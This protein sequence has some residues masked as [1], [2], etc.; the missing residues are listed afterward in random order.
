M[1]KWIVASLVAIALPLAA[2]E[3]CEPACW[4]PQGCCVPMWLSVSHIEG[5]GVGYEKGYTS[6]D[7]FFAMEGQS[8]VPFIDLRGHVFND[9]LPAANGGLGLR[10]LGD[11]V[12]GANVYY[13]Y[14]NSHRHHYNQGGLGFESLGEVWDFRLNGYWPGQEKFDREFALRDVNAEVG[15]YVEAG[16]QGS[17]YFGVGPYYLSGRRH[18]WGAGGRITFEWAQ[19]LRLDLSSCYDHIYHG[20]VQ[21]RVALNIPLG[22]HGCCPLQQRAFERVERREIIVLDHSSKRG[23]PC[24]GVRPTVDSFLND[25]LNSL[26]HR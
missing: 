15:A 18:A 10:Y 17:L 2:Q 5:K 16:H 6:L 9:G 7:G 21:G 8:W 1:I 13:D 14:R 20:D 23:C 19:W 25:L 26:F 12:W 3:C 24:C 22:R 4:E 11:R